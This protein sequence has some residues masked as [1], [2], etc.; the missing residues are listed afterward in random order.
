MEEERQDTPLSLGCSALDALLGGGVPQQGI[1][2]LAGP[3]GAGK[4]QICLQL[5]LEAQRATGHGEPDRKLSRHRTVRL[6]DLHVRTRQG[7]RALGG[8]VG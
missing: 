1:T 4:T 3:S 8:E 7:T 6:T 2:E 5:A